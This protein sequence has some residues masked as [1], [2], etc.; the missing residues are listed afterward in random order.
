MWIIF[1]LA[2]FFSSLQC[3]TYNIQF[4]LTSELYFYW[5]MIKD[6]LQNYE[7][8]WYA[9]AFLWKQK[10]WLVRKKK[11]DSLKIN[12]VFDGKFC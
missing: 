4:N 7:K 2:K 5:L 3:F 8:N 11:K 12:F 6:N 9:V 1:L 10:L